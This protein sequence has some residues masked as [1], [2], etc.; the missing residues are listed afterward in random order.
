M[1]RKLA[2]TALAFTLAGA[3]VATQTGCA[4][5][6]TAPAPTAAAAQAPTPPPPPAAVPGTPRKVA[7][8][9]TPNGY[10]PSP[11]TLRKGEPVELTITRTTDETCAHE[12]VLEEAGLNAKLPLN[13]PVT[14]SFTPNRTGEL[15]YGCAMGKMVSGVFVVQ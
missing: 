14:V 3:A 15:K 2:K 13:Q 7:L 12:L 10:E 8:T 6:E 1:M 9:V 11:I 5:G 4:K